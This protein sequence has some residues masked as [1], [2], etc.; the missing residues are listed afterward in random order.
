MPPLQG[1]RLVI[2][3]YNVL[4]IYDKPQ[5]LPI[6]RRTVTRP[7]GMHYMLDIENGITMK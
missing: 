4:Q 1:T 6:T 2:S 5:P 3:K 7:Y